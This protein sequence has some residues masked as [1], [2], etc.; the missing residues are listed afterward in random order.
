MAA[1]RV[2]KTRSGA[3]AVACWATGRYP[4]W[5]G[6]KRFNGPVNAWVAGSTN[7]ATR[8]TLQAELFGQTEESNGKKILTGMGMIP[9]GDILN[10]TWRQ[11]IPNT[12]DTVQV[13]HISGGV[14]T[15]T[16][17]AYAQGQE[18]FMGTAKHV[19]W[20]DEEPPLGILTECLTRTATTDGVLLLTFTPLQGI[21][22]AA[23]RFLPGEE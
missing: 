2:G 14:S 20:L 12:V 17:K 10:Q 5:W 8:D 4:V 21:S 3:Y 19:I 7:E 11:S 1:N 9:G 16:L 6:G 23:K 18:S 15:I 13:S 22:H